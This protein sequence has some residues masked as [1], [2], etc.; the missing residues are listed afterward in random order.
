MFSGWTQ[1]EIETYQARKRVLDRASELMSTGMSATVASR[2]IGSNPATLS[3]L[4]AAWR[5]VEQTGDHRLMLP[6]KS[7]GRP[8]LAE[9]TA[10]ELLKLKSI[11]LKT[12]R[13]KGRGSKTLAARLFAQSSACSPE[14]RNAILKPRSS[15]HTLTKSL[16][17]A[18]TIAPDMIAY[19]RSPTE[20]KLN[21]LYAPGSLRMARTDDE[22]R[23]LYAGERQSWDDASINFCVCVPW[24]WGGDKCSDKFGFRVG[25]FQLLAGIDDASD[26]CPGF[27][28]VIRPKQSYNNKDVMAAQWRVWRDDVLPASVML[29]GGAWQANNAHEFYRQV[30]VQTIDATGRPHSKLIENYWNRLWTILSLCDGQIGRYRAEMEREND[31]LVRCQDGRLDPRE[32]FPN[33]DQSLQGI[34]AS[35]RMLSKE[36]V[37]SK[38]YGKWIPEERYREDLAA[39]PRSAI[40][41]SLAWTAAPEQHVR[42]V[43]KNLVCVTAASPIGVSFPYH[44][45]CEDL[46]QFR[47][48]A[49]RI[50]FDP[51]SLP[52]EA[53]I[54]LAED[55]AG[56]A[57]GTVI[58][59]HAQCLDDPAAIVEAERGLTVEFD[60]SGLARVIQMRKAISAAI[61]TE[62]RGLGFGGRRVF[63]ETKGADGNM[64]RVEH[65]QGSKSTTHAPT[66]ERT[67]PSSIRNRFA[68]LGGESP[69]PIRGGSSTEPLRVV[70]GGLKK[71]EAGLKPASAHVDALN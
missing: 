8:T 24:P 50:H 42:K 45:S 12:N 37:E 51:W 54:T 49:V 27:S 65:G 43:V 69:D 60:Q 11:Y 63:S 18:M 44:F 47:G 6:G 67:A 23:R 16:R 3:R 35:I 70:R 34:E 58:T 28:F 33:L 25:R 52:L 1:S 56:L 10:E 13:S 39:H 61:R 66:S 31:L 38:K 5:Q 59:H 14:L 64:L 46:W 48:K 22:F 26:F 32:A 15:K 40:E 30:G 68:I 71:E 17:A 57:A 29:E 2:Q 4:Q 36:P 53:T 19:H 20:T 21:G 62:Y 9:P 7:T 55:H 41:P